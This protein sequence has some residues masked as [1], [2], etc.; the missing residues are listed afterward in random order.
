MTDHAKNLRSMYRLLIS[1]GMDKC[2]ER[3]T[4]AADEIERLGAELETERRLSFRAQVAELE[5][6]R[7][8]L[9]AA[10]R[11]IADGQEMSGVFTFADVVLRYQEIAR[12]A[13]AKATG[14]TND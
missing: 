7:E 1:E 6:E 9:L 14:E 3:V 11:R 12:A 4:E 8:E 5:A 13:I 2:A 10:V